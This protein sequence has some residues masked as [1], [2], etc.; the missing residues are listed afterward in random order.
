M[1]FLGPS[2]G[3]EWTEDLDLNIKGASI[4]PDDRIF[5]ESASL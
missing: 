5:F 1:G 3:P 2:P 4:L